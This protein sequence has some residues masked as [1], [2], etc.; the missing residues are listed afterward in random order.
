M[1]KRYCLI[2]SVVLLI[3]NGLQSQVNSKAPP[4]LPGQRTTISHYELLPHFICSVFLFSYY[5]HFTSNQGMFVWPLLINRCIRVALTPV[6]TT[7]NH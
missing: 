3:S 1:Y 5:P 7:I 2:V 4:E 6:K